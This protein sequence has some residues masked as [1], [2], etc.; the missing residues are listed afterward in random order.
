MR[1]IITRLLSED[2]DIEVIGQAADAASARAAI[3]SLDPDVVTLDIQMP[4]MNGLDFLQKIME[5]RPTPVIIISSIARD[6]DVSTASLALKYGAVDYIA[7]QD[8]RD[9]KYRSISV[10]S[11]Q[12][13]VSVPGQI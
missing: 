12:N 4:G 5:L 9:G 3:K 6:R 13:P 10:R 11:L 1:K 2:P 7:K 8:L